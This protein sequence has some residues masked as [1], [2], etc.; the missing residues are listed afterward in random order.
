MGEL[1]VGRYELREPLSQGGFGQTYLSLDHHL[2]G[3]PPCVVKQLHPELHD[4]SRPSNALR[5]FEQEAQILY[6][7]GDHPQIPRLL[8]HFEA[9]GR[10]Y[11]VQ[12]YIEGNTL[13]MELG[14][15]WPAPAVETMLREVLTV[16]AFVHNQGVIHRDLKPSNLMRRRQDGRLMLIDFGAVKAFTP[17]R[18]ITI[19]IGTPGY[20]PPEQQAGQP[21]YSS[22]L[23]ALG[24][25]ALEALTGTR[26]DRLPPHQRLPL[27]ASLGLGEPLATVLNRCIQAQP[28]DRYPNAAIA[29]AA[30]T[31]TAPP[32][33]HDTPTIPMAPLAITTQSPPRPP[34]SQDRN[35]QILLNKVRNF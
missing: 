31:G 2:P 30:L 23:F 27:L 24:M 13:E 16:L 28:G 7:L 5:L 32:P 12:D 22:D 11:L 21:E 6:Q 1:L 17:Q 14:Q 34:V 18:N 8:A 33:R 10:F 3:S 26:P 29:L 25:I 15:P 4:V 20:M 19:G 35:R 9:E